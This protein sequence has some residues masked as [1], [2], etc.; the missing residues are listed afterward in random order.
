MADTTRKMRS[1]FPIPNR[2][3][4][5]ALRRWVL[6]EG[7]RYAITG[8]LLTVTFVSIFAIGTIWT[9][10]MRLLLTETEAVQT[11]LNTFLSGIIL[12]VSIVV[13]INSIVL[14]YDMA[15]INT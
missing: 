6:L 13:S 14:S 4:G 3:R 15:H 7:N 11:I 8:A 12:L 2:E 10:E 5:F 9:F 1:W